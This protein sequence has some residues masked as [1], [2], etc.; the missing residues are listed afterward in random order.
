MYGYRNELSGGGDISPTLL[1][2]RVYGVAEKYGVGELK[3]RAKAKFEH[4]ASTCWDMDDFPHVVQE[5]YGSTH[6]TVR[7]LRDQVVGVARKKIHRLL[8]KE[9]FR[10]VLEECVGFAADM[11]QALARKVPEY[12][13]F[14]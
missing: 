10:E 1:S 2:A 7:D 14:D 13:D 5:V 9:E 11:V 8:E 12:P 3:Q 4:A 6:S